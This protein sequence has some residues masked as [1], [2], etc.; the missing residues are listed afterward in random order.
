[1]KASFALAALALACSLTLPFSEP[2][3]AN[4]CASYPSSDCPARGVQPGAT[5]YPCFGGQ[6]KGDWYSM[7]SYAPRS[8]LYSRVGAGS[9]SDV[10]CFDYAYEAEG[11]GFE[12]P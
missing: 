9:G 5:S 4:A 6:I 2:A 7:R 3:Q 8:P 11:L 1:M 12:S 10:W